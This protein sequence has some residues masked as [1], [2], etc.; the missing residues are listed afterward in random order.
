M[1]FRSAEL[2]CLLSALAYATGDLSVLRP[3]LRTD[4]LL[5]GEPQG[6]LTESQQ[7][8]IREIAFG[9]IRDLQNGARKVAPAPDSDTL[10]RIMEF[11]MAAEVSEDY[12]PLLEEEL[13]SFQ[14]AGT[15]S[16]TP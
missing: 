13:A 4:P 11:L 8:E 9:V 16:L 14:P 3:H 2:P 5:A 7:T 10:H 15:V 12:L 6:G 1:L